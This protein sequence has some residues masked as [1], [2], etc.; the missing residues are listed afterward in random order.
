MKTGTIPT[1]NN[2]HNENDNEIFVGVYAN[3]CGHIIIG[4]KI[5]SHFRV[6]LHD[7]W[8]LPSERT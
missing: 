7:L 2:H 1:T 6:D 4:T 8:S 3:L 5:R